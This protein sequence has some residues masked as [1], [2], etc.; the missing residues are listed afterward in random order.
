MESVTAVIS[1]RDRYFTTLPNCL[2]SIALQTYRPHTILIYDDGEHKDLRKEPLYE[3]IFRFIQAR[4]IS[5]EVHFGERKGQVANHQKSLKEAPTEWIWRI[6]DDNVIESDTLE[7]LVKNVGPSV[8]A[9][10]GLV[11]DPKHPVLPNK[12][13]S[14]KI[15][16]IYL[17]LNEQ[18]FTF[19][20]V[21]EVD[22]LYS[23][24]IYS[25]T[26]AGEGYCMD[27][28]KIGHREETILTYGMK[29]RGFKVLIDPSAVTWH[30]RFSSGG[31]RSETDGQLWADDEKV[32]QKIMVGWG[33]VPNQ[34]KLIFLDSG[35]GDHLVFKK[36][37]PDIKKKYQ[38]ILIA[39]CYPEVFK[40]DTDVTLLSLAEVLA[41]VNKDQH[42]IYK[43]M[44]D[45]NWTKSL[46][47]AYRGLYLS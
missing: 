45:R 43:W 37:L 11:L 7:K 41:I 40:D 6:D 8:G 34:Y 2:I 24:F 1:T 38:N 5:W 29:R 19:E 21:K 17:C 25:K 32:F 4:G 33:V 30:M 16:D 26:A 23:T 9:I 35:L 15:E 28:S 12:L 42:N 27:L 20:G 3:N 47:E 36:I 22:H 39:N 18:W 46:E 13:A 31:I 14:N 44:W 10:G